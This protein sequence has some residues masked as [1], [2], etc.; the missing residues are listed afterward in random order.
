MLFRIEEI[1]LKDISEAV[2]VQG[3]TNTVLAGALA[4]SKLHI[5]ISAHPRTVKIIG[6]FGFEVPEGTRLIEPL[7]YLELLQLESKA[8]LILTDS[9]EVQE[10]SYILKIP[11]VTLRKNAERS[12]T[13]D[14]G[15]NI[16]TCTDNRTLYCVRDMKSKIEWVNP[17]S[18]GNTTE[19]IWKSHNKKTSVVVL[20]KQLVLIYF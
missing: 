5:K 17:Y 10:K 4:A 13:V 12:E 6:E 3:D 19:L 14:V 18:S 8:R 1:L 20:F 2:L 11:C 7:S 9:G 16:I 15:A